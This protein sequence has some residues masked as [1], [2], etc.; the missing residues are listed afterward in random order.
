M[1]ESI[2]TYTFQPKITFTEI[3]SGLNP[4]MPGVIQYIYFPD[5]ARIY[6]LNKLKISIFAVP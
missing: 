6:H 2:F 3:D 1:P 5:F 4:C